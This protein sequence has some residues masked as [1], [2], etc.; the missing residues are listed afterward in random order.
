MALHKIFQTLNLSVFLLFFT[1]ISSHAADA[2]FSWTP[3]T[4]SVSG[5]KIHYGTSS[6][7]YTFVV[8]AGLPKAV[9]GSIVATVSGLQEGQTYYFSATAYT[10]T[11]ESDYSVEV[12]YTVGTP[13]PIIKRIILK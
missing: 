3:N 1:A 12:V 13:A 5:Y 10:A 4:E 7:N 6:H 8:D 11:E 9:N 2:T